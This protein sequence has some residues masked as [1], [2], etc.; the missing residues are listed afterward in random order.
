VLSQALALYR[1]HFGALV[2]TCALALVPASL[3]ASGAVVF[4]LAALGGGGR[5]GEAR[6][7]T[8]QVRE[9]QQDFRDAPPAAIEQETRVRQ[10]GREAFEGGAASDARQFLQSL[11]PFAYATVVVAAL[12]LA[13]LFLAHAAA[14]PLVLDLLEGRATGPARAWTVVAGRIRP[15][16]VTGILGALLVGVGALFFIVPGLVLAT[17]FCLAAPIALMENASGHAALERSWH[18]LRGHWGAALQMWLLILVISA[19]GSGAAVLL[20]PGPW[21]MAVSALVRM[22]LY[23]LPLAGLV[24]VYRD[25]TQYMRR[26]SAPG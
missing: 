2:L 21:R 5:L 24:L 17:G 20:P 1:R 9:K 3:L 26:S 23:P 11:A 7:D 19:I 18:L 25:A 4:G 6:T 14:V 16:A 8:R 13:G 10:L 15:L 22:L 12:L